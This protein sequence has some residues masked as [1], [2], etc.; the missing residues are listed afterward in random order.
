VHFS[1]WL[2]FILYCILLLKHNEWMN[3]SRRIVKK[4][5]WRFEWTCFCEIFRICLCDFSRDAAYVSAFYY[6][7]VNGKKIAWEWQTETVQSTKHRPANTTKSACYWVSL[8]VSEAL[9]DACRDHTPCLRDTVCS[10]TN[11]GRHQPPHWSRRRLIINS[12]LF[13]VY[14]RET[15][16]TVWRDWW[17]NLEQFIT[18]RWV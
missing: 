10:M 12:R 7:H 2:Y 14:R 4:N 16:A 1:Q 6:H 18:L 11:N 13:D 17:V 8:V 15:D 3:E 5:M 9:T